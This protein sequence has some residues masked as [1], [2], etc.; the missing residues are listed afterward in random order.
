MDNY[1]DLE[2]VYLNS[3][4]SEKGI[5]LPAVLSL[6]ILT[7]KYYSSNK[8]LHYFTEDVLN[9]NYKEYLF[10][11]RTLLLSRVIKDHYLDE[12]ARNE[13]IEYISIFFNGIYSKKNDIQTKDKKKN[14]QKKIIDDWRRIIDSQ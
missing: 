13:T 7:K 10:K 12:N 11:S 6:I 5:L 3:D 1:K 8:N 4:K 14:I 9:T 2:Q